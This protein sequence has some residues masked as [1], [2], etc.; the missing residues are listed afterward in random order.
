MCFSYRCIPLIE[1]RPDQGIYMNMGR[2][3]IVIAARHLEPLAQW[4]GQ[5][6]VAW[7]KESKTGYTTQRDTLFVK[8][9]TIFKPEL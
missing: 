5:H 2:T 9:I 6:K 8:S 1:Y 3:C 7:I 4:L